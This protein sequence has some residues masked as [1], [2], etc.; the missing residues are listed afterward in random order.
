MN[1]L[2]FV[3]NILLLLAT[4]IVLYS[5]IKKPK[6]RNLDFGLL[7]YLTLSTI[8]SGFDFLYFD[9][10][11]IKSVDSNYG[12][13]LIFSVFICR[14]NNWRTF[15]TINLI[16]ILLVMFDINTK[17]S[18]VVFLICL[19]FFVVHHLFFEKK[20]NY[21]IHNLFLI[22]VFVFT[23]LFDLFYKYQQFWIT[24]HYK[25]NVFIFYSCFLYIFYIFII[26]KYAK[27]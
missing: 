4:G 23:F 21:L 5:A 26:L 25:Y 12:M 27:S 20:F 22:S 9:S 15:L 24:S 2:L 16:F 13:L 14:K 10:V 7:I 19:L 8:L 18:M 11:K 17:N 3:Y 6:V 1:Y